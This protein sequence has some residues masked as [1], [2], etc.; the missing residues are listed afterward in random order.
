MNLYNAFSSD[1]EEL[2]RQVE[3]E[4]E[5]L[6]MKT[7]S[8]KK[9]EKKLTEYE[10]KKKQTYAEK[11][12]E[13]TKYLIGRKVNESVTEYSEDHIK[14]GNFKIKNTISFLATVL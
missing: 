11:V 14:V 2:F 3:D 13:Y 8:K 10:L 7:Q 9:P 1:F 6:R 12:R 5:V 4:T